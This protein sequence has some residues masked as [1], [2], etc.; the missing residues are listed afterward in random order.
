MSKWAIAVMAAALLAMLAVQSWRAE[1]WKARAVELT[2][3]MIH[4]AAGRD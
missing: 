2:M 3:D 4:M 1:R